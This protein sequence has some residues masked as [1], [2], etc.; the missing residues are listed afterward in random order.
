[1][2]RGRVSVGHSAGL[3]V[4]GF[5][6]SPGA[7]RG[8][9]SSKRKQVT[10]ANPVSSLP[11]AGLLEAA[12]S[13]E[14]SWRTFARPDP[15][16]VLSVGSGRASRGVVAGQRASVSSECLS[17]TDGADSDS[18]S[19]GSSAAA[20]R[21]T[22]TPLRAGLYSASAASA[23]MSSAG[24]ARTT[25]SAH[26]QQLRPGTL[27]AA[28][29]LAGGRCVTRGLSAAASSAAGAP[30]VDGAASDAGG[31]AM[32]RATR[33][34]ARTG[35]ARGA[36]APG[37]TS[38]SGYAA[39]IH[40]QV[41]DE[42]RQ[43]AATLAACA[44]AASAAGPA[45]RDALAPIAASAPAGGVLA[46]SAR[47]STPMAGDGASH[48]SGASVASSTA[49][50][51]ANS[52]RGRA[53]TGSRRRS[54][55]GTNTVPQK[56][57]GPWTDEEDA[58][59]VRLV[60][61]LG[62]KNWRI[63]AMHM[64]GRVAKQCRERWHHHLCPGINKSAWTAEEDASILALRQQLGNRWAEIAK[65]P[66]LAGRTDNAIKNRYNSSLRKAENGSA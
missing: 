39:S 49:A 1:M 54:R 51:R 25:T 27:E 56:L 35:G 21:S 10:S 30:S 57:K 34:S 8:G 41:R 42:D 15:H 62:P 14:S 32:G 36:G 13:S 24:T 58:K 7:A 33:W 52:S 43:A 53:A 61:E 47:C 9:A 4:P 44:A 55:A 26:G 23:G 16:M 50:P 28:R 66:S 64:T 40:N 48:S 60:L 2:Q 12:L 38:A 11:P 17:A 45:R 18:R 20:E 65:H 19:V 22:N 46:S 5:P 63:I 37:A 29:S 6:P 3:V 31:I 59:L